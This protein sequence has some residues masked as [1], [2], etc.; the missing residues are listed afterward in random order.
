MCVYIYSFCFRVI[1]RS[2]K[3][4]HTIRVFKNEYESP[5]TEIDRV[6]SG[7]REKK[8][9]VKTK[10]N[11]FHFVKVRPERILARLVEFFRLRR[12]K[13]Q[14][15]FVNKDRHI[16]NLYIHIYVDC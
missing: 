15:E 3:N 10:K 6:K 8:A 5:T 11:K 16:Y 2:K 7:E 1:L 9:T 14:C 12:A 4:T 13:R